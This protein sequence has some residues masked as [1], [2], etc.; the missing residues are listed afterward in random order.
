[1]ISLKQAKT[2]FLSNYKKQQTSGQEEAKINS[3]PAIQGKVNFLN[4]TS[5]CKYK[6]TQ[7]YSPAYHFFKIHSV[8]KCI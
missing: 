6:W 4:C 1:M 7:F 5:N 3:D 8:K 2:Y